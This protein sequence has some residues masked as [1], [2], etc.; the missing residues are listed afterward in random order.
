MMILPHPVFAVAGP[1]G[2]GIDVLAVALLAFGA[3]RGGFRGLTGELARIAGFLA[4]IGTGFWVATFWGDCAERWF[5]AESQA[6]W[7]GLAVVAGLVVTTVSVGQLVRWAVDR[8]LRLLL[9]QP[10][11]AVLGVVAGG[12]RAALLV[13]VL[14]F[15][16]SFVAFGEFGRV[17]FKDSDAGRTALP[18][19][20]R[21]RLH[22]GL[23]EPGWAAE[24]P[25]EEP[26]ITPVN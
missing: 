1:Y 8:F 16:A 18:V 12:I 11:N 3:A 14:F 9:D 21:L 25:K 23:F 22:L 20:Q 13:V 15:F 7:R 4:A 10:A 6:A 24:M 26:G 5:P 2:H 19:V 17:L